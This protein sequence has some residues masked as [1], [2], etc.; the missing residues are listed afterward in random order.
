MNKFKW[1]F[2]GTMLF[3]LL[4]SENSFSQ[5]NKPGVAVLAQSYQDSVVLR[6]APNNPVVWSHGNSVGYIVERIRVRINQKLDTISGKTPTVLTTLKPW[7]LD[8][9]EAIATSNR[10]AAIAAQS[11][12]GDSFVV[13]DQ[14]GTTS[15][16]KNQL[17]EQ[18][19]RFS[20]S[21]MCADQSPAVA[22]ALG[23]RFTDINII[24]GEEYLYRVYVSDTLT[25]YPIDTGFVSINPAI[26]M[27]LPPPDSVQVEFGD[28]TAMLSW[29]TFFLERIYTTYN[30]ERSDD[31][32]KNYFQP[33]SV[34]Y[35][36][37]E[38]GTSNLSS[39][40]YYVDSIPANYHEFYYRIRGITP[41][42]DFG[43]YST[44][45]SGQGFEEG[46]LYVP[47]ISAQLT[48][49]T[50]TV[51]WDYP[52]IFWDKILGYNILRSPSLKSP[53][54]YLTNQLIKPE[55]SSFLDKNPQNVNYYQVEVVTLNGKTIKSYE[56]LAQLMD[57]SPPSAPINIKGTINEDGIVSLTWDNNKEADLFGYRVYRANNVEDEFI[58]VTIDAVKEPSFK[59]SINIKVLNEDIYYKIMAL[60]NHFN[61]SDLSSPTKLKRPDIIPPSAPAIYNVQSYQDSIKIEWYRSSS[62]DVVGYL[63]FR[64]YNQEF[65][66]IAELDSLASYYVDSKVVKGE[67]YG[68]Y[69]QAK[70][71][72]GLT[73]ASAIIIVDVLDD[74][75]RPKIEELK[76][77]INLEEKKII[78]TW[79]Y[80]SVDR[81][82]IYKSEDDNPLRMASSVTGSVF[83]FV[84]TQLVSGVTYNYAVKA[85]YKN[86]AESPLS[87]PI[88]VQY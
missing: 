9:W 64:E 84:D 88:K 83:H 39:T 34:K 65:E 3:L 23:L 69:V 68:Y 63:L 81:F 15:S 43:P 41:F 77:N 35:I 7:P 40:A 26:K 47:A 5:Q 14:Q 52:E 87:N 51:N 25:N 4:K 60:D 12:Y 45:V 74:G 57:D 86:G 1:I 10:L 80:T 72:A 76:Y 42:G 6:W 16:I 27:E 78:L 21:L 82:I 66:L 70:D 28:K 29:E 8:D 50:I 55:I 75:I 18:Q 58:Q 48:D 36:D 22:V 38:Q 59:D 32:G 11:L 54:T 37:V 61:P 2:L 79:Q 17:D 73:S 67:T 33:S 24:K 44:P 71:D 19:N 62:E 46:G 30:I 20:F 13:S 56:A 49:S 53:F 85:I 31:G